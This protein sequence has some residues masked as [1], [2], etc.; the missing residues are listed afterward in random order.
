MIW[1]FVRNEVDE[2]KGGWRKEDGMVAEVRGSR[3][4]CFLGPFEA[5]CGVVARQPKFVREGPLVT[6]DIAISLGTKLLL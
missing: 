2:N 4:N 5:E 6:P 3:G 1:K